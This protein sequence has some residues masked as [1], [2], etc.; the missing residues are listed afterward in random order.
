MVS[1]K[2]I[3]KAEMDTPNKGASLDGR[4]GEFLPYADIFKLKRRTMS[5]SS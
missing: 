2:N 4:E 3:G 1:D 5:V